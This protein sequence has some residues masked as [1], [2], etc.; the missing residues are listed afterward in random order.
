MWEPQT[1]TV[2]LSEFPHIRTPHAVHVHVHVHARAPRVWH[3][4]PDSVSKE[5]S[6]RRLSVPW[7]LLIQNNKCLSGF[8]S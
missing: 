1:H 6:R 5:Q 7:Q 8:M 4:D 2:A 3:Y